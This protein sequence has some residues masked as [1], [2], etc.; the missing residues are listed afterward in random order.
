MR[1][2]LD[3]LTLTR[4]FTALWRPGVTLPASAEILFSILRG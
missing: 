1:I 3:N 2:P 4:P